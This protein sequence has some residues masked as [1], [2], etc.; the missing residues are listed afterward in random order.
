MRDSLALGSRSMS[1]AF[2]DRR[3][4]N[5]EPHRCRYALIR[6]VG[7]YDMS[8]CEVNAATDIRKRG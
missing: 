7:C 2:S 3:S 8:R 4:V 5:Y 1:S 6:G